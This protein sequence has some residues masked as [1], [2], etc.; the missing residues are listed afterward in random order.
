MTDRRRTAGRPLIEVVEA[1][2]RGGVDRVLL[3]ER[4]LGESE[5]R[6]LLESLLKRVGGTA[7]VVLGAR[8]ALAR[9]LG[10]LLHLPA[11]SAPPPREV[12]LASVAAHDE[13]EIRCAL[14]LAPGSIVVGTA[15]PTRSKPGVRTLG[16]EGIALLA[17]AAGG[18]PVVAIGGIDAV[19]VPLA[20]EAGAAGV[21]VSGAILEADD[22][23]FAAREI[24]RAAVDW[25]A[26]R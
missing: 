22:P 23:E 10:S 17:R 7:E 3:R 21:A 13:D 26:G 5:Y 4:D 8:P 12:A 20:L 18:V 19:R 14:A 25:R 9:A 11:G 2:V 6:R 15:F 1:A 24:E 16:P